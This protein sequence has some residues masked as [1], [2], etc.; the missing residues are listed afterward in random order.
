LENYNFK[1]AVEVTEALFIIMKE[2]KAYIMVTA[3]VNCNNPT[4]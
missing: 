3:F 1:N 2:L 4:M